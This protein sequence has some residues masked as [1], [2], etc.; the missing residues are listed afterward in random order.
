LTVTS[1]L[2][3]L[4]A[5]VNLGLQSRANGHKSLSFEGIF[6]IGQFTP[7]IYNYLLGCFIKGLYYYLE[8][9]E[10]K[11]SRSQPFTDVEFGEDLKQ[12]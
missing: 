7:G 5:Y 9:Q 2:L 8:I 11:S 1:C 3:V 12:V 6:V 10:F 4:K